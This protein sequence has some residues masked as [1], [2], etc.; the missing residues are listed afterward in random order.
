M[1]SSAKN[2]TFCATILK[3][4]F[5]PLINQSFSIFAKGPVYFFAS[6]T[7]FYSAKTINLPFLADSINEGTI[8]GFVKSKSINY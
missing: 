5:T 1:L 3:K 4:A 7:L 8:A 2:I 6:I